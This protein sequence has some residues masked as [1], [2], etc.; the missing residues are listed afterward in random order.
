MVEN[1]TIAG[2]NVEVRILLTIGGCPMRDAI[3]DRVTQAVMGVE[4]VA[5]VD[6][7]L[8]VMS[9]EQRTA[10]REKLQ[11]GPSKEIPFARPGSLTRV[12]AVTSG[13]GGVGKSSLTVNLA[14]AMAA[15]GHS[16]GIV[17]ADIYGHSVPNMLG[18]TDLPTRVAEGFMI[19]PQA[20]GVKVISMLPF[21][22]GG[23]SEPVAYRGPLLHR[24]LQQF[25]SDFFWGDLDVLLL[26]LPPGTGDIAMSVAQ[27]IPSSEI[28]VVTTPQ[29]AA[30][31][32]AL[33]A[34]ILGRTT[35]QNVIGVVENMS[36]VACPACGEPLELFG[37]GGGEM[38]AA[39]LTRQ[40]GAPARLLAQVPFDVRLREGGDRGEPLVLSDPTTPA[41]AAIYAL[42]D[43]LVARPRGLAGMSLTVTPTK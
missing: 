28:L 35:H 24:V 43:A 3:T 15:R 30:A 26:D 17:D 31:E 5:A 22:P 16:V 37:S 6:V 21:K 8:G 11:G 18:C 40:L 29:A 2:G 38:V 9:D 27:L 7:I 32:V 13:K 33:R 12:I 10:L 42:A 4:G 41:A 34:G 19:P 39:E 36:A 25:L 23:S 20:H 1:F 14:V